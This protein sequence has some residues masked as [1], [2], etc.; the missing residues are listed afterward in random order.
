M[1][2]CLVNLLKGA[3]VAK[4]AQLAIEYDPNPMFKSGNYLNAEEDVIKLAEQNMERDAKKNF[5]LWEIIK[6][7]R[8]FMK[9]KN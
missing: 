6:N 3:K 5:T 8:T 1:A 9:L 7:A 2:I 4:A